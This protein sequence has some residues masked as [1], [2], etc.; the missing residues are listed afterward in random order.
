M[1]KNFFFLFAFLFS[2]TIIA[3]TKDEYT[4]GILLEKDSGEIDNM[5]SALKKE[6][7]DVVGEDA[8]LNFSESMVLLNN[9]DL[10]VAEQNYNT[11][12]NEDVDI[13]I[14]FGITNNR[15]IAQHK[16]YPKPTILFGAAS[17]EILDALKDDLA[18]SNIQNFTAI[19]TPPIL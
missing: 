16:N 7:I 15:V 3:Q 9:F 17:R 14:S 18:S 13:I 6:I 1:L 10:D 4:I 19:I 2:L 8:T 5:L 11:L 12:L